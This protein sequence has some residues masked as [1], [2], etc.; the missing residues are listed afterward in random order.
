MQLPKLI[1]WVIWIALFSSVFMY[2]EFLGG[3]K[4]DQGHVDL[5]LISMLLVP[6]GVSIGIRWFLLPKAKTYQGML[7]FFIIGMAVAES[8]VFYG[9]FLFPYH[10]NLFISF[11]V[12]GMIQ[13]FPFF[14]AA[15]S[16]KTAN[17]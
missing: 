11:A 1:L 6:F 17:K 13:F 16:P 15:R 3:A 5:F 8:L 10:Q 7:P 4:P 14:L 12:I 2:A 9:I